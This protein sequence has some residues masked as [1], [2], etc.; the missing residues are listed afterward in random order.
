[1]QAQLDVAYAHYRNEEP[2][3]ALAAA[4][5]FIK[6]HP[7]DPHVDYAYYLKGL[8][9][10]NRKFGLLDRYLPTDPSQRDPGS[11]KDAFQDFSEL[12]TRFPNSI[13]TK[14]AYKRMLYLR[15]NLAQNEMHAARYYLRRGA[16]IAAVNRAK[17]VIE[18]YSK[19]TA[20]RDALLVMAEAYG[21]LGL[22]TL[23]A[24]ARRVLA[25]NDAKGVFVSNAQPPE[26]ISWGI[27]IWDTMELD[28]D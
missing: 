9:N 6:L 3:S 10:Y 22:N 16:Y 21:Q 1:M 25:I 28:K 14:D 26:E 13:Y 2:E 17:Y 5:R 18:N 19:T 7:K 27:R 8:V 4:D 24:D 15:D 11:A 20:A 12:V 23:Q